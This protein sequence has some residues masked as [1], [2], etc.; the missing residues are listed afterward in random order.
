VLLGFALL[1]VAV[2]GAIA[3]IGREQHALLAAGITTA[4]FNAVNAALTLGLLDVSGAQEQR[5][6]EDRARD[7]SEFTALR[8]SEL[9]AHLHSGQ[10]FAVNAGLDVF[11]TAT[12]ALLCAIAAVRD[13]PIA[14]S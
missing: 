7:P 12:G 11:Y 8:E 1:S 4:S 3:A 6:L 9:I 5:I 14:G 2:G 13:Q 10:F